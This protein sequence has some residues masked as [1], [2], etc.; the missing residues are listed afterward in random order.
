MQ[1]WGFLEEVACE[2]VLKDVQFSWQRRLDSH[3][4]QEV[5]SRQTRLGAVAPR[6]GPEVLWV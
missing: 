3:L 1:C 5:V 4:G 2:Q 6:K